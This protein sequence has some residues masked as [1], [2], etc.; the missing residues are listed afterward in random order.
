VFSK[1]V[2]Q[3]SIR[4]SSKLC[5]GFFDIDFGEDLNSPAH[6][7]IGE[8]LFLGQLTELPYVRL[9]R[10]VRVAGILEDD[11]TDFTMSQ[12]PLFRLFSFHHRR[13]IFR[14]EFLKVPHREFITLLIFLLKLFGTVEVSA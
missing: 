8:E 11:T 4:L 1:H 7:T 13:R 9:T 10:F 2:R 6:G 12:H 3:T 5:L 14:F